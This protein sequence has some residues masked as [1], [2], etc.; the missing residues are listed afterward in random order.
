[1]GDLKPIFSRLRGLDSEE[2]T[3]GFLTWTSHFPPQTWEF[4]FH[5]KVV[6][7]KLSRGIRFDMVSRP[8]QLERLTHT[9]THTWIRLIARSVPSSWLRMFHIFW[10]GSNSLKQK[11]K[12]RSKQLLI[13]MRMTQWVC[14][15]VKKASFLHITGTLW[16]LRW[17]LTTMNPSIPLQWIIHGTSFTS[18]ETA[19][20][21]T[22]SQSWVCA[23]CQLHN[24]VSRH[25]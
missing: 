14:R 23:V 22:P 18:I 3:W 19:H 11:T 25:Y 21:H 9:H 13:T 4:L 10:L 15:Y 2:K 20:T 1:M 5:V 12:E 24:K 7:I 17:M 16:C 6:Y 8:R